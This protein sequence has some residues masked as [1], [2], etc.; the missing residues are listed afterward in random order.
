MKTEEDV[1]ETRL[2]N[3]LAFKICRIASTNSK[4]EN[5]TEKD[6]EYIFEKYNQY[7]NS[8]EI[9]DNIKELIIFFCNSIERDMLPDSLINLWENVFGDDS[10]HLISDKKNYAKGIHP[11]TMRNY[12]YPYIKI[13]LNNSRHYVYWK[14]F[15]KK[16]A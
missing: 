13:H 15:I 6:F 1:F 8:D 4:F 11:N 3:L 16:E 9:D 12:L 5:I 10:F 14:L 7:I 2:K